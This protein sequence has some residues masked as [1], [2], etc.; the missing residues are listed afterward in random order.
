MATVSITDFPGIDH[1][2]NMSLWKRFA[3]NPVIASGGAH[4]SDSAMASDPKVWWDDALGK[5]T[6]FCFGLGG[7]SGGHADIMIAC[8]D[9]LADGK[10]GRSPF[11]H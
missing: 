2:T 10:C 7:G 6:M 4:S 1:S 11:W 5:W 8:A 9:D 3:D